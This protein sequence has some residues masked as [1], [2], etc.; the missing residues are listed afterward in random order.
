M[1]GVGG[2]LRLNMDMIVLHYDNCFDAFCIRLYACDVSDHDPFGRH[3]RP[4]LLLLPGSISLVDVDLSACLCRVAEIELLDF[5]GLDDDDSEVLSCHRIVQVLDLCAESQ[6][7]V[8]I[9]LGC[10]TA[11]WGCLERTLKT[12]RVST[13]VCECVV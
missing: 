2:W 11:R 6:V 5:L 10:G 3:L 9:G 1:T 7:L 12:D 4:A 8:I 13:E